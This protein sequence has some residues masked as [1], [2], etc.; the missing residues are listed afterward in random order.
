MP[1]FVQVAVH[2][3]QF[4]GAVH[5][6]LRAAFAARRMNHKFHYD[7]ARRARRWLAVHAAHSPARTD[8][9]CLETYQRA[10]AAA[11]GRLAG[12]DVQLVGLGCGGGQKDAQLLRELA[13]LPRRLAYVPLDVSLALVLI[14][15]DA[16]CAAVPENLIQ[17]FVADLAEAD[18]LPAAFDELNVAGA[19]R[20]F[21]FFG[22]IPNFEPGVILPRLAALLRAEDW[23]LFSAN[24]A[25]GNDYAAGVARVLPQYDNPETHRWLWT[26]LED[27]GAD[28]GDGD[29][30]FG[31]EADPAAPELLRIAA[32]WELSRAATLV[33]DEETFPLAAG[34]RFR[35]FFS[36][37]H[38]PQTVERL[39]GRHGLRVADIWI[40]RSGEEGVFLCRRP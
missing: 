24:L 37:R 28:H 27:H 35:L 33:L 5:A 22:M 23:L 18:D 8:P 13:R 21:T 19:A 15:R 40:T 6:Q 38:T 4:P 39:L 3:S 32:H 10:F 7:T 17:P 30:R 29:L 1:H 12:A 11:A 14:A 9:D 2:P 34:E 36:Y 31:V 25:P 26:V 20:L 16:A